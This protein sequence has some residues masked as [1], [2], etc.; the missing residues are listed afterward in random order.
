[1]SVFLFFYC[2]LC[3]PAIF[4]T[5]LLKYH[6]L[7]YLFNA[8]IFKND[9][10]CGS[11]SDPSHF[12][13]ISLLL[14]PRSLNFLLWAYS[15]VCTLWNSK[16]EHTKRI[17]SATGQWGCFFCFFSGKSSIAFGGSLP[18]GYNRRMQLGPSFTFFG[19]QLGRLIQ[20]KGKSNLSII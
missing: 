9:L 13:D 11:C 1:M 10:L 20:G 5:I 12:S 17:K 2:C 3:Q 19:N 15:F 4:F 18:R 8:R 16:T 7:L 6:H 14:L